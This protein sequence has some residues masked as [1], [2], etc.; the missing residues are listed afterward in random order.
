[1]SHA[2]TSDPQ[3]GKSNDGI[4]DKRTDSKF[5]AEAISAGELVNPNA[6]WTT[7]GRNDRSSETR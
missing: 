5:A 3:H 4:I 2:A 1:M 6:V 7:R